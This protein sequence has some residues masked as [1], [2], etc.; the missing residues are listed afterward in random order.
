MNKQ[1][2]LPIRAFAVAE[3]RDLPEAQIQMCGD[4]IDA[5]NL[6]MNQGVVRYTRRRW[7]EILG[8]SEG[9]LNIILNKGGTSKRKRHLDPNLFEAVE[10]HSGNRAISQFFDLQSRGKLFRQNKTT[11]KQELLAELAALEKLA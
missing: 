11:R 6:C 4:Y 9:S 3:I 2:C 7:A 1:L 8:M 10:S 5:V